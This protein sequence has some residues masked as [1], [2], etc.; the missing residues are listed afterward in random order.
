MDFRETFRAKGWCHYSI[1]PYPR[2]HRKD[3]PRTRG[4]AERPRKN[5]RQCGWEPQSS[6]CSQL[7][8]PPEPLNA[9]KA[10][11]GPR[12]PP[13]CPHGGTRAPNGDFSEF[14]RIFGDFR[15]FSRIFTNFR[16]FSRILRCTNARGCGSTFAAP[17]HPLGTGLTLLG[18]APRQKTRR[19]A[20]NAQVGSL[21]GATVRH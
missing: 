12:N 20:L 15:G 6:D 10:G 4:S 14:S 1:P 16:E 18:C 21:T 9:H 13:Q 3:P 5:H 11:F 17:Y 2:W 19:A 8:T 7:G